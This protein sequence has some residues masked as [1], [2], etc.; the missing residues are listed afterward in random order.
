M[1]VLLLHLS[2]LHLK[3]C[4]PSIE[5]RLHAI[6][7]ALHDHIT[8]IEAIL[9][10]F[11][12][13]VTYSG[14]EHQYLAAYTLL[15]DLAISL[16]TALQA[17]SPS[18]IPVYRVVIPGN[19]D[20]SFP[21]NDTVR[22][23]ILPEARRQI[24]KLQSEGIVTICTSPQ[25]A[26]FKFKTDFVSLPEDTRDTIYSTRVYW[27]QT[28]KLGTE[29]FRFLCCN[30]AMLSQREEAPASILFP[31]DAIT[32]DTIPDTVTIALLHHPLSR[33]EQTNA[34]ELK[35]R[36]EKA[37]DLILTGHEHD[38][39]YTETTSGTGSFHTYLEGAA[40]NPP[41]QRHSAFNALLIDTGRRLQKHCLYEW[42]SD[43]RF[44]HATTNEEWRPYHINRCKL[45]PNEKFRDN[46]LNEIGLHLT[47]RHH[48]TL[49][50]SDVF[51]YPDLQSVPLIQT[52]RFQ[53]LRSQ[54]VGQYV[55]DNDYLV[56]TGD[57]KSG[58]T[59]LAKV[60][61]SLLYDSGFFPVLYTGH[62]AHGERL[63]AALDKCY[64]QQYAI[65]D[66]H[67]LQDVPRAQR[68]VIVDDFHN[69]PGKP[70][71][72]QRFIATLTKYAAKVLIIADSVSLTV[73]DMAG[74]AC[75]SHDGQF[76]EYFDIL[77]FGH[78]RRDD[79]IK[80]WLLL[81]KDVDLSSERFIELLHHLTRIIDTFIGHNFVPGYP[82]FILSVLQANESGMQADTKESTQ[83]YFYDLLI[84]SALIEDKKDIDVNLTYNF[85][86]HCAYDLF[87]KEVRELTTADIE[88]IHCQ[89]ENDFD[90]HFD[91]KELLTHL[92]N[93]NIIYKKDG[94][95]AF[96]YDFVYYY[97]VAV[98]FKDHLSRTTV[99]DHI[100]GM[101]TAVYVDEYANILL[102][103]VHLV[104]DPIVIDELVQAAAK[105]YSSSSALGLD[106]DVKFID[107][108]QPELH[109]V[110]FVSRPH[111]EVRKEMLERL[112]QVETQ[113]SGTEI[114]RR[115]KIDVD[116]NELDYCYNMIIL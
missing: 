18:A 90:T 87:T 91:L 45:A 94:V 34:R 75:V 96:K 7:K 105:Q 4:S 41:D 84:K 43:Q 85:L 108:I 2:D 103:L 30:T 112:D 14:E 9:L 102:F 5:K 100:R 95:L 69:L 36:L 60:L 40:L 37:A 81:D 101:A 51:V 97:F 70:K 52:D 72:K 57:A 28:L 104:K 68:C 35:K 17:V 25:D 98:F 88:R 62:I 93:K 56:I 109:E 1:N 67:D 99:C 22:E 39:S 49:L 44:V 64:T 61:Y 80:K 42:D 19:H 3:T 106:D 92:T 20:C 110:K 21:S 16:T 111:E 113:E 38:P 33:L 27:E 76:F 77:P 59:S 48:P 63:T 58:K 86:A 89:Y 6:P 114:S 83:G 107:D 13:D 31:P 50:L 55:L 8:N 54:H 23:C 10:V 24:D 26:F 53:V 115:E 78:L 66:S 29:S 74:S 79:L 73:E 32:A 11:T 15:D 12:G 71:D 65:R 47:H 82:V 116:L 46:W